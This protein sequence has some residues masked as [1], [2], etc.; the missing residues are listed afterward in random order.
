MSCDGA[1]VLGDEAGAHPG[2]GGEWWGKR[3]VSGK[4]DPRPTSAGLRGM[5]GPLGWSKAES[6]WKVV[7]EVDC[8]WFPP[9]R[10]AIHIWDGDAARPSPCPP[11]MQAERYWGGLGT[12]QAECSGLQSL[13]GGV[14]VLDIQGLSC[15]WRTEQLGQIPLASSSCKLWG[16]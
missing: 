3:A 6:F 8:P 5:N 7:P 11:K 1:Q 4:K 2:S 14:S 15:H 12:P 9:L 13:G 10:S 16:V